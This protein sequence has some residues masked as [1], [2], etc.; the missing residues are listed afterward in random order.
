MTE[1][2]SSGPA[3]DTKARPGWNYNR[4]ATLPGQPTGKYQIYMWG[5]SFLPQPVGVQQTTQRA[6]LAAIKKM[7]KRYPRTYIF[8]FEKIEEVT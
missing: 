1:Q 4:G 2:S 8:Y 3:E 7:R 5:A 6:A